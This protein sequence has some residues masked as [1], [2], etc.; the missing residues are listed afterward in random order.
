MELNEATLLHSSERG[1]IILGTAEDGKQYVRKSG[2]FDTAVLAKLKECKSPFLAAV[3]DYSADYMI[4]EY[5]SGEPLNAGNLPKDRLYEIFSEICEGIIALHYAGIIHRDIKPSNIMLTD[6][7]KIKIIDYDA[8]RLKKPE[9]DKD[10]VF[11]GTDGFAAPEQYG[12]MQTDERSDIYALGVTMK[13]LLG[14]QYMRSPYK[15]VAEKCMRFDPQK[16]YPT[17]AAVKLALSFANSRW[18]LLVSAV[19]IAFAL[20]LPFML[21]GAEKSQGD[22]E[23]AATT[24]Y[25]AENTITETAPL[26][27]EEIS[28]ETT[29][30]TAA[31]STETAKNTTTTTESKAVDTEKEQENI[32]EADPVASTSSKTTTSPVTVSEDTTTVM[33]EINASEDNIKSDDIYEWDALL[34]PEGFPR[35]A[36]YVSSY[37]FNYESTSYTFE[38]NDM[39]DTKA[40]ECFDKLSEWLG[41]CRSKEF[42]LPTMYGYTLVKDRCNVSFQRVP[43]NDAIKTRVVVSYSIYPPNDLNQIE[44]PD[45]KKSDTGGRTMKWEDID[46]L[47]D[48]FPKL[49][50]YVTGTSISEYDGTGAIVWDRM[51]QSEA[52]AICLKIVQS[53]KETKK[54]D[55]YA[56]DD[57]FMRYT[58]EGDGNFM[59]FTWFSEDWLDQYYQAQLALLF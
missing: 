21:K 12:F 44:I 31:V 5:V 16:R 49:T 4:M 35:L 41:K 53:F 58:I 57:G 32:E 23:T 18:L 8:A 47:Y 52:T 45:I 50:D 51:S 55:I 29:V 54:Y 10:T 30:S 9:A 13:L 19:I 2:S 59:S 14:E 27:T 6:S 46:I 36:D 40:Q 24:A 56:R 48:G 11:V 43:D 20:A 7:G 25:T 22:Q 28:D 39:D 17:V 3:V 34:V 42:S 1:E 33:T 37:M 15:A 26:I 38:W